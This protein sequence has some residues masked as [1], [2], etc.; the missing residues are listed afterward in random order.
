MHVA[1]TDKAADPVMYTVTRRE[2]TYDDRNTIGLKPDAQVR[3]KDR[4]NIPQDM[5]SD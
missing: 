4:E 2:I 1:R 5:Q 3:G